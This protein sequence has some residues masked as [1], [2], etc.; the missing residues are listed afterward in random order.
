MDD[1]PAPIPPETTETP[2]AKDKDQQLTTDDDEDL[3]ETTTNGELEYDL[4]EELKEISPWL[5]ALLKYF[6]VIS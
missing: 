3:V 1:S 5:P 4:D 2:K 6:N